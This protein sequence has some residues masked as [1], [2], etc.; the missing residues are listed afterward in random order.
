MELTMWENARNECHLAF[1]Y[2]L[3][4]CAESSA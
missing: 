1:F 3:T 4:I 2:C